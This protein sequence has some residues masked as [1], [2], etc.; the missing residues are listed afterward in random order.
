M[1]KQLR[2]LADKADADLIA[3][4]RTPDSMSKVAP[5]MQRCVRE[6]NKESL[7]P[8]ALF[9]ANHML[10]IYFRVSKTTASSALLC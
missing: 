2:E 4:G 8:G 7:K 10:Q 3:S 9:V 6:T 5:V 1:I